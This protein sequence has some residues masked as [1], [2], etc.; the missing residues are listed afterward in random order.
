MPSST[1]DAFWHGRAVIDGAQAARFHSDHDAHDLRLIR[2]LCDGTSSVLD[3]GAGT[4]VVPNHLVA[5]PGCRVHAVDYVEAFLAQAADD[6]RLTTEVGDARTWR[7][8]TRRFDLIL[9]L[10]VITSFEDPAER[11]QM[12]DNC[13]AMLAPG[14]ALLVKAQ[15]GRDEDV[16]VDTHSEDLGSRYRAVYAHLDAEVQRLERH[17]TVE[18]HD[19]FPPELHRWETTF[20]RHLVCRPR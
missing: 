16:V 10:G 20:F 7:D 15:F 9:S 3:L 19:V 11:M 5:D 6:P 2:G 8:E 17:F 12:Y 13:A 14:G 1:I 4:C 18:V